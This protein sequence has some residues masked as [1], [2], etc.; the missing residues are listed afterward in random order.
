MFLKTR[1]KEHL[2]NV[3]KGE[4]EKSAV[5]AQ[6]WSEKHLIEKEA[7]LLKQIEKPK[8][9]T[10]WEKIYI[11][12]SEKKKLMNFEIPGENDLVSRF[13]SQPMEGEKDSSSRRQNNGRD[14]TEDGTE[15]MF[16]N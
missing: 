10:V 6:A 4:V 15:T 13:F 11:Q 8:E 14:D 9:L 3:K 12:K 1:V 16:R 5:A 2:R 7:K